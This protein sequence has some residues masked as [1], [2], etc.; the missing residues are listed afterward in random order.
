M[1]HRSTPW[2]FACC[3]LLTAPSLLPAADDARKVEDN[4]KEIA[5]TA[6]FLR[7]V[8]K[9]FALLEACDSAHGR[10]TLRVE[11]EKQPRDWPVVPD[12][13]IKVAGWWGRLDQFRP[14]DRVWAWFKTDRAK[15]SVAVSMLAD[16]LSEQDIHGD[17]LSVVEY[18]A[19]RLTVKLPRGAPWKLGLDGATI[20][21]GTDKGRAAD[22]KPGDRVY[23]RTAAR[24][25]G[26]RASLVLDPAA[27]EARRA[28]QR[29]LLRKRWTDEGLPGTVTFLHIF[30]GE[31]EAMLDHEA[32][33]WA[34]SLQ[35]GDKVSLV[36]GPAT[37]ARP[38]APIPAVVRDVRPWRERTQL[39]LVVNGIDQADLAIG[40]RVLLRMAPPRAETDTALLPPDAD[41][42]RSKAERIDWFL[43]TVYCPCGVA[44][45]VCTGDFYTLASCNP[46]AC[47]MPHFLRGA[48]GKKID[49]GK[50]DRQI[51]EELLKEH[52]PGLLR[53]H[54]R[55]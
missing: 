51:L 31:M 15:Q 48:I 11:G 2:T 1:F 30:S 39:R 5:G 22:L 54:L 43:A 52:G 25:D 16:E 3:V 41:R 45:D 17:G 49:E 33:R 14:G 7:S 38:G 27:F 42:P 12:A 34:R 37:R 23:V 6:E 19:S 8:P 53:Q 36:E 55:P 13:E 28:A 47:G 35:P 40:Q 32:Q 44:G 29:A 20:D 50:S 10:V 9:R 21:R 46:N 24:T 18:T 4:V 26:A